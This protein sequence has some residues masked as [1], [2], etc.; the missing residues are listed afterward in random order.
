MQPQLT[1][2]LHEFRLFVAVVRARRQ[3]VVRAVR[4]R[5]VARCAR[6]RQRH[7]EAHERGIHGVTVRITRGA[8]GRAGFSWRTAATGARMPCASGH[9][10]SK[11]T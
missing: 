4:A 9:C 7:A 11:P 2:P 6:A 5:G 1:F 10:R 3:E 8:T